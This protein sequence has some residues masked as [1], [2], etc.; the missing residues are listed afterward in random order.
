MGRPLRRVPRVF[1]TL[2]GAW[3]APQQSPVPAGC[4]GPLQ[5]RALLGPAA[6]VPQRLPGHSLFS[7]PLN[8][9]TK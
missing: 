6:H 8:D 4:P 3:K 9:F 2:H 7:D 1:L 5:G